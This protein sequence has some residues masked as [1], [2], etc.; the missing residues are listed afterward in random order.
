MEID[1][2]HR[3]SRVYCP[4]PG[5]PCADPA[6]TAGYATVPAMRSHIDS[7]LA[8]TLQGDV[9]E[10]WMRNHG[11]VRCTVCG[12][13]VS[14]RQ[15]LHPT[16]APA[17]RAAAA[18]KAPRPA[19]PHLPDFH[20]MMAAD[21]PVL[22]HVP[23]AAR[24]L[25]GQ[26]LMRALATASH[27]ND[28]AS[29]RELLMLPRCV[30]NAPPRGGRRHHKAAAAYTLDRLQQWLQGE[31]QSLWESRTCS[32]HRRRTGPPSAEDRRTL[33]TSLAREGFD[34]KACTALLSAGLCPQTPR[35]VQALREL[36]P[37]QAPPVVGRAL[38][39]FPADTAPGPSGLRVQHL[40]EAC[41]AGVSDALLQQI[42]SVV[43]LLAQGQA[44]PEAAAS[45]AGASLVAIPKPQA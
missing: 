35:T 44:C 13:S 8:G 23:H 33:A 22:R 20:A 28:S 27:H 26:V 31:R 17:G 14:S 43:R 5:C 11:R 21:S 18:R 36:H 38:R 15:G 16:C 9:P 12:L 24:H 40:R 34:R 19:G 6:Q 29:W 32:A 39:S 37:A 45:L 3:P 25:W 1:A 30:L 42:A 41:A 10:E 4:V 7:H 2:G